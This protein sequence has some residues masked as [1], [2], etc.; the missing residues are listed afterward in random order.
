MARFRHEDEGQRARNA[1]EQAYRRRQAKM[2]AQARQ[3][4]GGVVRYTQTGV[5]LRAVR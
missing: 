2:D 3:Y 5:L 1:M 4:A